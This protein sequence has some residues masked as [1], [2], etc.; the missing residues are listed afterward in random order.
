MIL[1]AITPLLYDT[2]L[3]NPSCDKRTNLK[4]REDNKVIVCAVG[5]VMVQQK[6]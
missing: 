6:F 5:L 2:A 4:K 3:C 1:Y